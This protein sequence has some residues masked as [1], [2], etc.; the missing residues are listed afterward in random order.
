MLFLLRSSCFA[1]KIVALCLLFLGMQNFALGQGKGTKRWDFGTATATFTDFELNRNG[2]FLLCPPKL[3]GFSK[4]KE[5]VRIN[6]LMVSYVNYFTKRLAWYANASVEYAKWRSTSSTLGKTVDNYF[7]AGIWNGLELNYLRT[8]YFSMN[9]RFGL[10]VFMIGNKRKTEKEEPLN[11]YLYVEECG[12]GQLF[13]TND[14]GAIPAIEFQPINMRF[15]N[16]KAVY[17]DLSLGTTGL[18][19]MGYSKRF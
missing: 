18:V 16:N 2:S 6:P 8:K 12:F 9:A 11:S 10:G 14:F 3:G 13:P 17:L 4:A 5:Q 19:Q 7:M 1:S 15:G